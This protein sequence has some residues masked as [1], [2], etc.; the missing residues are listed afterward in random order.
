MEEPVRN[1]GCRVEVFDGT[2]DYRRRVLAYSPAARARAWRRRFAA[3][4]YD[5]VHTHLFHADVVGRIAGLLAG[6]PVIVKSLH[7]MGRWKPARYVAIDRVLNRWTDKIIC[8]SDY[9]REVAA[10]QER[11]R[12][13]RGGDDSA[14]SAVCP[15]SSRR[16]TARRTPQPS[17]SSRGGWSSARS[18][19][20]FPKRATP[21]S[22][23]PFPQILSQH[24]ETEFLIV[25]DGSLRES[26]EARTAQRAN[27]VAACTLRVPGPTF[28]NCSR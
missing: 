11:L 6:V 26:L 1:T 12:R 10:A 17:G 14:R 28:P 15:G 20:L 9:Q 27:S 23:R 5:V 8:C 19:G 7:N 13:R 18:A 2:Y 22:S 3:S 25:G 16:L 21:T 4:S 24:P